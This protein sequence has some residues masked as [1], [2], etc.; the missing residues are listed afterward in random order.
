[1][2]TDIRRQL[3][4]IETEND[5]EGLE[6]SLEDL[7][8]TMERRVRYADYIDGYNPKTGMPLMLEAQELVERLK[9]IVFYVNCENPL[10]DCKHENCDYEEIL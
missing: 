7:Y 4:D 6:S 5:N 9:K 3:R 1:M 10:D 2:T 8:R